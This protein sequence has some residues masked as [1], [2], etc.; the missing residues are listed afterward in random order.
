M[1]EAPTPTPL[2]TWTPKPVAVAPKGTR[3]NSLFV[4]GNNSPQLPPGEPGR[5]SVIAHGRMQE[6]ILPIVI[7]NNTPTYIT[8]MQVSGTA[9]NAEG[10]MLATGGDQGITPNLVQPGE[11]AFGYVYFGDATLP[12]GT[13]FEFQTEFEPAGSSM[14]E[15]ESTRDLEVVEVSLVEDRLVGML[16]NQ[17]AEGITG[18]ISIEAMCFE[19]SGQILSHHSTYA[20]QDS[21]AA[22]ATIPYQVELYGDPCPMFLVTGSGFTE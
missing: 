18:P 12:D 10:G 11:I 20:D 16:K 4:H 7:R 2:P 1:A 22:G 13:V 9:R 17:H 5:L 3:A 15:Y 19:N 21:A 8:N 6:S 14:E